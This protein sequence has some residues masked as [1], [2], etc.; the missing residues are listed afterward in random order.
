MQCDEN[1]A[2][3]IICL[4]KDQKENKC[5]TLRGRKCIKH[6]LNVFLKIPL[7]KINQS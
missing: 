5:Q 3:G 7:I 2:E 1:A 6:E 4:P